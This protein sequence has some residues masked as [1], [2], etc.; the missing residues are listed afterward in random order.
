M[1]AV[2]G[3]R[4][5]FVADPPVLLGRWRWR[6]HTARSNGPLWSRPGQNGNE[7]NYVVLARLVHGQHSDLIYRDCCDWLFWQNGRERLSKSDVL[8][9]RAV[10]LRTEHRLGDPGDRQG[11][12]RW[13]G[14]WVEDLGVEQ[15]IAH[16]GRFPLLRGRASFF[17]GGNAL[18]TNP[19]LSARKDSVT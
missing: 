15:W 12:F 19:G 9:T 1:V 7:M 10:I 5:G 6:R 17:Q 8:S 14:F 11:H 18:Q 4:Q 13:I 16:G 2:L 3:V